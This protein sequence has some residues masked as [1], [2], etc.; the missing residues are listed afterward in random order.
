MHV[1]VCVCV[2]VFIIWLFFLFDHEDEEGAAKRQTQ[3]KTLPQETRNGS[4]Q[5]T[6]SLEDTPADTPADV[7]QVCMCVPTCVYVAIDMCMFVG[8]S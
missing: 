7:T 2:C 1:C 3:K 6:G 4:D 5:N 8:Q